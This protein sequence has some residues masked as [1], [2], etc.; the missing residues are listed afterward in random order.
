[1]NN[2]LKNKVIIVTGGNG[3]LG[4]AIINRLIS[5]EAFFFIFHNIFCN[6]IVRD[7]ARAENHNVTTDYEKYGNT[8]TSIVKKRISPV[9]SIKIQICPKVK[10]ANQYC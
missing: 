6:F 7:F 5:E 9:I 1:M 8:D 10:T 4:K 3:L 2:R